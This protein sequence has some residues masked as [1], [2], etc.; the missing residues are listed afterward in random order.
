MKQ[1]KRMKEGFLPMETLNQ[2]PPN[3]NTSNSD[4]NFPGSSENSKD[5]N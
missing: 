5:S 2:S 1:K 4:T 3:A